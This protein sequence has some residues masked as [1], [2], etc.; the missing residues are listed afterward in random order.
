MAQAFDTLLV[1]RFRNDLFTQTI[2][3]IIK[4]AVHVLRHYR[5]GL[6]GTNRLRAN[7]CQ[8]SYDEKGW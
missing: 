8:Q 4:Q 3:V 5:Q 6:L 7:Q 1:G 2:V